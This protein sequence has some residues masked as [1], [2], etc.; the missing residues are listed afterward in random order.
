M[1]VTVSVLGRF[2]AYELAAQLQRHGVLHRLLTSLPASVAARFGISPANVRT[3]LLPEI[4]KRGLARLP[5]EK[6]G[7]WADALSA[8]WYDHWAAGQVEN[9]QDIFVGWSGFS[10]RALARAKALGAI[11]IV[12]RHSAHMAL[13]QELLS[14]EF[15]RHGLR[16]TPTAAS[17][18]E[19]E[20]AEYDEADY[21]SVPS[22]YVRRTFIERG[23]A[24]E[25]ILHTPLA[26]N[27]QDFHPVP[28][29]D[30]IFRVIHCGA[31][32]LR[33]GVPY[34]IDAFKSLRLPGAEL[35]L[36][37][38]VA[39]DMRAFLARHA[40]P[41]IRV[42]GPKPSTELKWYLGQADVFTL[43]SIEDGFG[44]VVPQAMACGL[45]VICTRNT[46]A[47]DIVREGQ[48]GFIVPIRSTEALREKIQWLY[49]H[50]SERAE[51]GA[52]ARTRAAQS[53][54]WNAY[55]DAMV[56][57]YR[58]VLGRQTTRVSTV[59]SLRTDGNNTQPQPA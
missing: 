43:A 24:P 54:S 53:F 25:R 21:L 40:S 7:I 28:K 34:L 46:C 55:G 58:A 45:P 1:K 22:L 41:Q 57:K 2:H 5:G 18:V 10:R 20:L 27:T 51:M 36:V 47:D 30:G 49:D 11:T 4:L 31:V 16:F 23:F 9:G 48:D 39:D 37:G 12:E 29:Q 35:W 52:Q 6:T 19:R 59:N 8:S 15:A 17:V 14:E 33:K 38:A 56:E 13:Q 44:M 32:S 42:L 26:T 50:P 3:Q